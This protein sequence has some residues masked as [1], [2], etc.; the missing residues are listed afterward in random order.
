MKGEVFIAFNQMVEDNIGIDSWELLLEKVQP[1][2]KGIYT[3]VEAYADEE[4]FAFVAALS[5]MTQTPQAQ[6]IEAFGCYLFDA[7]NNKHPI[8]TQQQPGFFG[9]IDSIDKVIHQE[10]KKLYDT[11]NLPSLQCQGLS[12]SQLLVN[13]QSPRKLCFLAEG[14]IRGAAKHYQVDYSLDHRQ[15]MH[16]GAES[17][18]FLIALN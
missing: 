14:L 18:E 1:E 3:S 4:L 10:V 8:F 9:F 6:L 11:E 13:Y 2:S 7:L 16:D 17:C 5:E 12:S 15:C